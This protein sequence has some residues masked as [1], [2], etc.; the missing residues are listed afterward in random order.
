MF[1]NE[2]GEIL[3]GG[4]LSQV[5]SLIQNPDTNFINNDEDRIRNSYRPIS[6]E[7][8][9]SGIDSRKDSV[10]PDGTTK[11]HR[12]TTE[13]LPSREVSV[14]KMEIRREL[15]AEG[16][17][18]EQLEKRMASWRAHEKV[19]SASKA[20]GKYVMW[21]LYFGFLIALVCGSLAYSG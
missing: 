18:A 14:E 16:S 11:N 3:N 15:L 9:T 6:E 17:R 1:Y 7:D 12:E 4:R 10:R 5:K 2:Q 19:Q 8:A 13:S 20:K 21:Q